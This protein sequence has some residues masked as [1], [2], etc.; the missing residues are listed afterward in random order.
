M[1]LQPAFGSDQAEQCR[2]SQTAWCLSLSARRPLPELVQPVL[3]PVLDEALK[4][5][6]GSFP[7]ATACLSS[8]Q[9]PWSGD[10]TPEP[11]CWMILLKNWDGVLPNKHL[12]HADLK[13]ASRTYCSPH[14]ISQWPPSCLSASCNL[15]HCLP[16]ALPCSSACS[17]I[18]GM[19]CS[20]VWK[21]T[22]HGTHAAAQTARLRR[23]IEQ[24]A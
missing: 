1:D 18:A 14:C 15:S 6:C 17:H 10:T 7:A 9:A 21:T 12:D 3:Q 2:Y 24:A 5:L 19:Q 20:Q 11:C 8:K 16:Q 13:G 22:R 4:Q 23:M